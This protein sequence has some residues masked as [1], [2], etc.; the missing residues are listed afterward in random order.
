MAVIAVAAT[1]LFLVDWAPAEYVE[2]RFTPAERAVRS[3]LV[4]WE[5]NDCSVR[6]Y[7]HG[8]AEAVLFNG[9][10]YTDWAYRAEVG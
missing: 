7:S 10:Q 6:L 8:P 9:E 3:T 1:P 5:E 2:G 4:N